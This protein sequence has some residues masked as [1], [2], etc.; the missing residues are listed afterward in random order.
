[1]HHPPLFAKRVEKQ[2]SL[3][4]LTAP[5]IVNYELWLNNSALW[6]IQLSSRHACPHLGIA[7]RLFTQ[8]SSSWLAVSEIKVSFGAV[9]LRLSYLKWQFLSHDFMNRTCAYQEHCNLF[10]NDVHAVCLSLLKKI[11]FV[12]TEKKALV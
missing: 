2:G 9:A 1:M 11:L 3:N 12:F 8:V 7:P 5:T 4:W 6:C 10:W